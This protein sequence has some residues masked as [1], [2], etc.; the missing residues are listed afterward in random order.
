MLLQIPLLLAA[1]ST[2]CDPPRRIN[3]LVV[4]QEFVYYQKVYTLSRQVGSISST[5]NE[6]FLNMMS[7]YVTAGTIS[8]L[9]C[10]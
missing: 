4:L 8:L 6:T 1:R 9:L 2:R 3:A 5:V 10:L 7:D